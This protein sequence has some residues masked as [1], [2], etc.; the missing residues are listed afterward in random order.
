[1]LMKYLFRVSIPDANPFRVT[2]SERVVFINEI[3]NHE[4]NPHH[5]A[6][7]TTII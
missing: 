4:R 7:T 5:Y 2:N 1:M 3:K 6:S